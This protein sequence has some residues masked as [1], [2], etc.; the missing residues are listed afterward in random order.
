MTETGSSAVCSF[1]TPSPRSLLLKTL[2]AEVLQAGCWDRAGCRASGAVMCIFC[3]SWGICHRGEEQRNTSRKD[4]EAPAGALLLKRL[5]GWEVW[6]SS[7][8]GCFSGLFPSTWKSFA[9]YTILPQNFPFFFCLFLP[10]SLFGQ[11]N[12]IPW[13]EVFCDELESKSFISLQNTLLECLW[14][15]RNKSLLLYSSRMGCVALQGTGGHLWP[16]ELFLFIYFFT[17]KGD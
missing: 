13:F 8:A 11:D 5:Q 1:T 4:R 10:I 17:K 14:T 16:V 3:R 12:I 7:G 15:S 6:E 2:A 9:F